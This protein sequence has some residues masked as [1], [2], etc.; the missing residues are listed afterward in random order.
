MR[1]GPWNFESIC[2]EAP[3]RRLKNRGSSA[4][5]NPARRLTGGW[6]KVVGK[7]HSVERNPWVSLVGAGTAGGGSSTASSG[8]S[9][10]GIGGK[11]APVEDRRR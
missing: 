7:H 6:G 1:L 9:E 10:Y 3:G 4:G 8:G 5:Q 11:G 2:R